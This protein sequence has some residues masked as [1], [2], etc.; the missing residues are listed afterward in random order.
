[1]FNSG[2]CF[3]MVEAIYIKPTGKYTPNEKG[4]EYGPSMGKVFQRDYDPMKRPSPVSITSG[5]Y[6]SMGRDGYLESREPIRSVGSYIS[7]SKPYR[8]NHM[9]N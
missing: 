6:S 8:D 5:L 3:K 9:Y 2:S 7:L 4:D 1:M